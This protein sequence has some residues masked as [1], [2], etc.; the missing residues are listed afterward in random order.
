MINYLFSGSFQKFLRVAV[1][2]RYLGVKNSE[3]SEYLK[4]V[5]VLH[6]DRFHNAL[7]PSILLRIT[8]AAIRVSVNCGETA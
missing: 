5:T 4:K 6:D 1:R 8:L 3:S 2:Q 7:D